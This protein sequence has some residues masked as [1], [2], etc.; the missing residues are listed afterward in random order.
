[1]QQVYPFPAHD[2]DIEQVYRGLIF[3]APPADRPYVVLNFVQTIDGQ[4]TLG[5][6]GAAGLGSTVD[7]RLMQ[8]LRMTADALMHGAGTVRKDNFPPRVAQ[9]LVPERIARGLARQTYG[10]VVSGSG[11][12]SPDNRYFSHPGTIIVAPSAHTE[13]L[14]AVFGERARIVQS[15]TKELDLRHALLV[16]RT[17]FNARV[18]LCEGGPTLSHALVAQGLL[19][20]VFLTVA[21]KL[22]GDKT[23]LRLLEGSPFPPSALPQAQLLHI[24]LEGSEMFLRYRLSPLLPDTQ[25]HE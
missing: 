1:M 5:D 14:K 20:E 13:R 11:S 15:G 2:L 22:G 23:A 16:L 7:H 19:D 12:L 8:R 6:R 17:E 4:T 10:V 18:V 3:P 25:Q 24:L 9:D 21:P